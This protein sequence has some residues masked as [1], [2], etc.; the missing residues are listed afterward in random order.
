MGACVCA[1]LELWRGGSGEVGHKLCF[2]QNKWPAGL[3]GRLHLNTFFFFSPSTAGFV[4]YNLVWNTECQNSS[5]FLFKACIG[6]NCASNLAATTDKVRGFAFVSKATCQAL[7]KR[8]RTQTLAPA[9]QILSSFEF[10]RLKNYF[11]AC[12]SFCLSWP[13]PCNRVPGQV[14]WVWV[15]EAPVSDSPWDNF[16]LLASWNDPP[17]PSRGALGVFNVVVSEMLSALWNSLELDELVSNPF[18]LKTSWGCDQHK[19]DQ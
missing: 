10:L 2:Q 6:C 18:C 19:I 9:L 3:Q 8:K 13:K 12:T 15:L 1:C 5:S 7:S 11:H 17:V 16:K 4:L 14:G